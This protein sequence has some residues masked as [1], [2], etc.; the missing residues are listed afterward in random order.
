M[1]KNTSFLFIF[2]LMSLGIPTVNATTLPTLQN[3]PTKADTE[4]SATAGFAPYN[5]MQSEFKITMAFDATPTN[6]L[7]FAIWESANGSSDEPEAVLGWDCG[8]LFVEINGV[9]VRMYK[10]NEGM[11]FETFAVPVLLSRGEHR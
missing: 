3:P 11:G 8:E 4:E 5:G 6:N 9:R 1:R 10:T 2:I 7:E